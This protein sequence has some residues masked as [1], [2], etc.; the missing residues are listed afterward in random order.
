M[1]Y[2]F[3]EL[4][5]A[6]SVEIKGVTVVEGGFFAALAGRLIDERSKQI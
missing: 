5:P 2:I 1:R 3:R 6:V 4:C